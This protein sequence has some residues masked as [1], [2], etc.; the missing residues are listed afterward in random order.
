[1]SSVPRVIHLFTSLE[2]GGM[3]VR[4]LELLRKI[5]AGAVEVVVLQSGRRGS[6]TE[7]YEEAGA[8][9][10]THRFSSLRFWRVAWQQLRH[11]RATAMHVHVKRGRTRPATLILLATLA[12][13]PRRIVHYRSDGAEPMRGLP[14]RVER[15]LEERVIARVA[16]DIV[17]VSPG[18]L[19]FGW[20]TEWETDPRC[21][22]LLA[23][24]DLDRFEGPSDVTRLHREVGVDGEPI[25]V[26]LG[27]DAAMKNRRLAVETLAAGKGDWHLVFIG[28]N[29]ADLTAELRSR[30][31]E[32]GISERVHW[33]GQ[34][35]DV[36]ELLSGASMLLLPSS[37]EGLPGAM[38][39][40][41]AAGLPVVATRLPGCEFIASQAAFP[42]TLHELEDPP[43]EWAQA[44]EA[45]L[46]TDLS[47]AARTE[48][49]RLLQSTPLDM[50]RAVDGFVDLWS[51]R[52][53]A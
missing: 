52:L 24:V 32:L 18:A 50:N 45:A 49:L 12:R 41:L 30:V 23:G 13:V 20:S 25:V 19:H 6:L 7:A 53:R 31:S 2:R 43:A 14:D 39:E 26:V 29:D 11:P 5:P 44:V 3:E 17:G 46:E 47:A 34:R 8:E 22:V 35:D 10:L 42:I 16:T 28:R 4:T 36:A 51:D 15:W 9:V 27:R 37:H 48:R 33:L 38:V 1:M 21:R 40:G